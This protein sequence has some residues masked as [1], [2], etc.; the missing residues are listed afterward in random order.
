MQQSNYQLFDFLDFSTELNEG[1]RLWRACMPTDIFEENGDVFVTVPF[2]KQNNSNEITPDLSVSKKEF[3]LRIKGYGEK[4]IRI[5]VSFGESVMESSEMLELS[6]DLKS[7][8]L[9]FTKTESEWIIIDGKGNKKAVI[10]LASDR[11]SVV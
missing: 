4:I 2:Q 7:S 5:S 8:P 9:S 3:V 10:G 11:K 6:S 1:D